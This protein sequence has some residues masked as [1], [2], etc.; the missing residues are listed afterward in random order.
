MAAHIRNASALAQIYSTRDAYRGESQKPIAEPRIYAELIDVR[1]ASRAV[2]AL[3]CEGNQLH[4]LEAK[5]P[6]EPCL[7]VLGAT[8]RARVASAVQ[9]WQKVKGGGDGRP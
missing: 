9:A 8:D 1:A 7:G 3:I 6:D 2:L 5:H 4:L